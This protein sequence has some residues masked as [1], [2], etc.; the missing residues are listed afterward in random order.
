MKTRIEIDTFPEQTDKH[1]S[2]A[3][4]YQ[5]LRGLI[6][7]VQNFQAKFNNR[8]NVH[9]IPKPVALGKIEGDSEEPPLT[10]SES[11]DLS[12]QPFFLETQYIG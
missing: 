10:T 2:I 4:A 7:C 8:K 11:T 6:Q 5:G 12:R 1:F 9:F 3:F